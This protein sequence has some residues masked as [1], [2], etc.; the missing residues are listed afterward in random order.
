MLTKKQEARVISLY[1]EYQKDIKPLTYYVE[2]KFHR[3]PKGL[4]KEFRDIYDHISR[5][6]ENNAS[7]IYIEDNLKKAENHFARIKLDTYKYVS[8][9]KKRYFSAW[10]KK[11]SKYDLQNINDGNFWLQVLELEEE[12]ESLFFE[13][14]ANEAKDLERACVLFQDSITKYTEIDK[15]ISEKRD[16]I[17]KEKFK[18]RRVTF[19][20]LVSG[21][22]LGII[23]SIIATLITN[24]IPT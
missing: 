3:F 10:K 19:G 5:C 12:G 7:D 14:R 6:Y 17:I 18:Y 9:Y 1:Q 13:A 4:L 11:Y 16:R 23:A 21:F 20:N 15:L 2:R 22:A 8:D 24:F